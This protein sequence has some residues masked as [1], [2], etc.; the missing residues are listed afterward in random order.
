MLERVYQLFLLFREYVI[1]SALIVLSL[2]LLALNDNPQMKQIRTITTITVGFLQDKISFIPRYFALKSENEMLHEINIRLA[3]EVNQ[4]REAKLENFRL[5]Q[6]LGLKESSP[7]TY[8]SARVVGRNISM[9]RN[10]IT[11][12]VGLLDGVQPR[13]TVV[14][15]RGV[16]GM[17]SD[18]TDH[19]SV[20]TL[21]WNIDFRAS[22]KVER[23]RVD[24]IIAWDGRG[25]ELRNIAK[26]LDIRQGDAVV[27]SEYS[28]TFPPGLRIGIIGTVKEDPTALFKQVSVI[29]GVDLVRLEEVFVILAT[30]QQE[31]T[32]LENR[33][34]K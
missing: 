3:D 11:L 22:A 15:E 23:S 32:S 16:V 6:L 24:G 12:N 9:L 7:Y 26:T 1:L 14:N 30:P 34:R 20:V 4:L 33:Q 25:L 10:C 19:F 2:I 13:M 21:I 17:V 5:H 8:L 29:P 28:S 27:T 18:V 31:K